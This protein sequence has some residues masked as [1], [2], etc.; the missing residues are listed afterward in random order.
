M[1]FIIHSDSNTIKYVKGDDDPNF[2][3]K[4]VL[5]ILMRDSHTEDPGE[6]P[7]VLTTRSVSCT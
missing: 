4:K 6:Q 5:L 2:Y 7:E 1:T 3:R